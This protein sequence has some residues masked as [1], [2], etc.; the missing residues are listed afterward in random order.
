MVTF[1]IHIFTFCQK[2]REEKCSRRRVIEEEEVVWAKG[3]Y[4]AQKKFTQDGGVTLCF[5]KT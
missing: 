5:L 4:F 2:Y 1:C 3:G